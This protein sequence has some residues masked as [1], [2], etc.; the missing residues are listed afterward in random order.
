MK[1][2]G[3][4]KLAEFKRKHSDARS[5]VE[6][7]T[8]EVEEAQW[9]S[10]HDVKRRYASA[11]SLPDG[12]VVFNLK[13]NRYRLRAQVNYKLGIVKVDRVGTHEEYDRW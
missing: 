8:A 3:R 2:I 5:Q 1:L 11:S 12:K 9:G 13:G 4:D 10:F 6:A 7:W